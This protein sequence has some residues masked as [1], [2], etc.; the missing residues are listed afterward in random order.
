MQSVSN[1]TFGP[2][3]AYLVPGATVLIGVSPFSPT[4]EQWFATAPSVSP[5]L[6][7]FLYIS[8][9]SLA[10]GMAVSAFRWLLI[11]TLHGLTGLPPPALDFAKLERNVEAFTLLIEL[12]YRHYQF[13]ANM[14]IATALTYGCYRARLGGLSVGWIDLGLL[15]LEGAFFVTSRDNLRK[16]YSRSQQL[17]SS[18]DQRV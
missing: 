17:L 8:I 15:V 10:V 7:G 5:T 9:L 3:I 14:L 4:L 11:D 16:Y 18:P 13:Y 12:H 2:L 6:G 1:D